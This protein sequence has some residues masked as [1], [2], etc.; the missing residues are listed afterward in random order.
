MTS[1]SSS[2]SS[3]SASFE[4]AYMLVIWL[5]KH[6]LCFKYE[7]LYSI[8]IHALGRAEKLYEA[9]LLSRKV[10]LT[11]LTYNALIGAC[12]RNYEFEKAMNLMSEMRSEGYQSDF[13]N[14][15]LI[16]QSLVR[17]NKIDCVLLRKLY[18]DMILDAIE[19]DG[20]LLNDIVLGFA[21]SGDVDRA[22]YF[23]S[24]IQGKGMNAR[25]STVVALILELGNVGRAEEAEAIFEEIKEGGLVPRTRAYNAVLKGY[26]KNGSLRDAEMIVSEMERNG[27]LPDEHTYSLLI[28]AYGNAGRWESA[29]IVLKE[30]EAKDVKPNS[31]V[32]SRILASYRDKGEWQKSFKVLKEMQRCGVKPDRQFYNVMIDTFGKY[33]ILDHVTATLDR[34]RSDGIEPDVVTYNTL[35]DCY[36]KSGDYKKVEELFDEMMKRGCLACTTTYNIM[37]NAFGLQEKWG[38]VKGLLGKMQSEGLLPNVVTYTTLIDVYGKSG[39]YTDAIECLDAMK[40]AGLKP[41]VTMYNALINAYAQRGLSNQA[42]N[43]F[44]M[45]TSDGL[46]PSNLALNALI[47]AFGEDKRDVEAFAGLKPDIVTYTTLMKALIRVEKFDEVPR[48]YEEM[49]KSGCT[50]DGKAR[51]TLRSALREG[52]N[53]ADLYAQAQAPPPPKREESRKRLYLSGVLVRTVQRRGNCPRYLAELL[54]KKKN[55]ASGA[56]GSGLRAS[57]KTEL[58]LLACRGNGQREAVEANW[59]LYTCKQQKSQV[60]LGLYSLVALSS[61]THCKKRI[62]KVT[63]DGLLN[64]TTLRLFEKMESPCMSGNMARKTLHTSSR[65]GQRLTWTNTHRLFQKEVENQLGKTIKSLRSDRGGEYMSQEFLDHLKDH[66][67]IAHRTPPYTPQHNGVSERRNRTLLAK[68][69]PDESYKLSNVLLVLCSLRC[70]NAFSIWFQLEG[71]PKDKTVDILSTN[72]PENKVLVSRNAEFLENSFITQEA[73]GSLE[74]LEIIQEEYTHPSIDTSLN[75][76]EDD[77]EIDEPQSDINLIRRST[78]TRRPIDRLCLYIDAEEHELG[79]LG[80]PLNYKLHV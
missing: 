65:K 58:G 25:T 61:W 51:A 78:R 21:K 27:V 23:L 68:F 12:A 75:H 34:M 69:D 6:R 47:N 50:P 52:K 60:R 3:T 55:T 17:S 66:G 4:T 57:R 74:D 24:L 13:V 45:M 1:S 76:K 49:V 70:C 48:V 31:F 5:E 62:E 59:L 38:E 35:I 20:Q 26:A 73:S 64:S 18:D 16:I 80:E 53:K 14:Y 77:L 79:D 29:R 9:F 19:L 72:P 36:C 71:D 42:A 11:P 28:D 15:S 10:K 54:K 7:L 33:N 63:H 40:S 37:I 56:G 41:S 44:K 2:S 67:I 30:M 39:R 43:T 32:F 22:M 8:L 46:R